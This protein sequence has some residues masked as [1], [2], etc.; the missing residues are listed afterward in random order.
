MLDPDRYWQADIRVECDRCHSFADCQTEDE[1]EGWAICWPCYQQ[2][3]AKRKR[4]KK[5]RMYDQG[6]S[7]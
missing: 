5:D 3:E 7:K 6:D 1:Q 4:N 2:R